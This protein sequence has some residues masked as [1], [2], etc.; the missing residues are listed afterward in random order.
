MYT[1]FR[2]SVPPQITLSFG[3]NIQKD[4]IR[5]GSDVFLECHI[6][7]NPW[8]KEVSW[9][10][11]GKS[12]STSQSSGIIVTNQSLVLQKVRRTHRGRYQC[13]A[14]NEEGDA[15]SDPIDLK[16]NCK[17]IILLFNN[18]RIANIFFIRIMLWLRII[19]CALLGLYGFRSN[20]RIFFVRNLYC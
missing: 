16:V 15:T 6:K 4:S 18:K 1:A 13:Q 10:F 3:A 20:D 17:S 7:A 11:N 9:L 12:L 8:I 14:V 19:E 5:E 2:V